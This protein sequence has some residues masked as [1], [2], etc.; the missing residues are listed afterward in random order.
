M[1]Y[2]SLILKRHCKT[3]LTAH[4]EHERVNEGGEPEASVVWTGKCNYQSQAHKVYTDQKVWVDVTATCLIPGDIAPEVAVI[5]AGTA[6]VFG[7]KR[8]IVVG[9]KLR[10][11]DGSVNYTR[12]ELE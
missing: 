11:P 3:E 2:P 9:A 10:N 6:E 8:K 5:S 12:L 7:E 4:L 1:R